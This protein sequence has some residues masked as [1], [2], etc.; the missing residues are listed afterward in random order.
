MTV[1]KI[2]MQPMNVPIVAFTG[3]DGRPVQLY[4]TREWHRPLEQMAALVNAQQAA[5]DALTARVEAL[6]G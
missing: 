1:A 4:I 2:Q 5:I 3:G 6:G